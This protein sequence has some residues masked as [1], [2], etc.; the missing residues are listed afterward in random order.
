[1]KECRAKRQ[2]KRSQ[3]MESDKSSLWCHICERKGHIGR[4]CRKLVGERSRVRCLKCDSM[5]HIAWEYPKV[6]MKNERVV[7]ARDS[8]R[9]A[10]K[11]IETSRCV[12]VLNKVMKYCKYAAAGQVHVRANVNDS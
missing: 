10:R 2:V 3:A 5:G 12:K 6:I 7:C 8:P 11:K 4:D 9:S 1:M